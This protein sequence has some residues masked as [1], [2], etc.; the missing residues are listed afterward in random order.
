V[1]VKIHALEYKLDQKLAEQKPII[2][3]LTSLWSAISTGVVLAIIGAVFVFI[4]PVLMS[5]GS[6][7]ENKMFGEQ[8]SVEVVASEEE[9][10]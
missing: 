8:K 6:W 5:G 1:A 10:E 9:I 7:L 3:N 2:A 4:F